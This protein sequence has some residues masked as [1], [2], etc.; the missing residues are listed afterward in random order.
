MAQGTSS[1]ERAKKP[2][3]IDDSLALEVAMFAS[4]AGVSSD[5]EF[6]A[7]AVKDGYQIHAKVETRYHF[8]RRGFYVYVISVKERKQTQI[9]HGEEYSW[10]PS[11]S[12]D[13]HRL[14]FYVWHADK[15]CIGLWDRE[16][17]NIDYFGL[18]HLS[19]KRSLDWSPSGDRLYY[20][21]TEFEEVGPYF[22][23]RENE[24][25]IIRSS[26]EKDP[27]EE[28]FRAS[29]RS[30]LWALDISNKKTAPVIA[31]ETAFYTLSLSP[32]GK[33][34]AVMELTKRPVLAHLVP[35]Y[36][37]L[38]IYPVEGGTPQT[39]FQDKI[40]STLYAWSPDNR[41]M[42]YIH[43]GRLWIHSLENGMASP[44]GKGNIPAAGTPVWHP[45]GGKILCFSGKEIC[46]FDIETGLTSVLTGDISYVKQQYFWDA[47][48]DFI[49]VKVL[50]DKTGKQGIYRVHEITG[51]SEEIFLGDY[52]VSQIVMRGNLLFFTLQKTSMPENIWAMDLETGLK[53]Q[54]TSLNEK[55][56]DRAF[57][58]SELIHWKSLAGDP[59][60]GALIYPVGYEKGKTYP[61]IFYV[62]ES[63]SQELHKF[64]GHLYNH[65]LLANL[66]F[67]VLLPDVKFTKGEAARSY[68]ESF[69]SAMDRLIDLGIANGKFGIYGRS[70]GGYATNVAITQTQRFNAAV[71]LVGISNWV[72][73]NRMQGVF[74]RRGDRLGQGRLGG[75]H[76]E[77]PETYI[78][79]S[80]VFQLDKVET[81]VLFLHGTHDRNVHFS[82]AEEMY[83][84]LR[85]LGK[86]AM[87]VAYPGEAHLGGDAELWVQKD[88]NQRIIDWFEKYLK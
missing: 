6:V 60:K 57:G 78:K 63:L 59:L 5:G 41:S 77:I 81:P 34:M 79:N 28:R 46:T 66:G 22:P 35:S 18:D 48:G 54:L 58:H 85:D 42:A 73:K 56:L 49:F 13:G 65:Q 61:V 9:T 10:A 29:L 26:W 38:D 12:P 14:A 39:V 72:S 20:F 76:W 15:I 47:Q 51:Q 88:K 45:D 55:F 71:S 67:G 8:V 16:A 32:D 19:G 17:E 33:K 43:D 7:Y 80:P 3:T 74:W 64:H 84:G 24:K 87:L 53:R 23:Y 2:F 69:V 4:A 37:K 11:W 86:T 83:Y 1:L 36:A 70:F 25:I 62:Y 21:P 52:L 40:Y 75:F 30:Q 27:Y 50:D 82:Q 44:F 31:K 68:K